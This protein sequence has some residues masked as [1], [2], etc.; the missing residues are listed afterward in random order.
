MTSGNT[1]TPAS[2]YN[3]RPSKANINRDSSQGGS[4]VATDPNGR[5]SSF[6]TN[7][8]ELFA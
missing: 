6:K 1:Q 4:S 7:S 2:P 3:G 5:R 8:K